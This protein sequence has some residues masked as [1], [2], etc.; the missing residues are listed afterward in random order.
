MFI[1]VSS[2]S[3]HS[4]ANAISPRASS[5]KL[6]VLFASSLPHLDMDFSIMM[7]ARLTRLFFEIVPVM[8]RVSKS[9]G[10][11]EDGSLTCFGL[12]PQGDQHST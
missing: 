11:Q 1:Q 4:A 3:A 7:S 2:R 10:G 9:C 5:V 6:E 12:V 8:W